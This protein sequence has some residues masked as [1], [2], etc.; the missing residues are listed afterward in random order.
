MNIFISFLLFKF[1]DAFA[2]RRYNIFS[3]F[4]DVAGGLR[5]SIDAA[6]TPCDASSKTAIICRNA[7]T[8]MN[9]V[10]ASDMVWAMLLSRFSDLQ[11][12]RSGVE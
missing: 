11:E 2:K 10:K 7:S 5:V 4:D 6:P 1:T 12:R 8:P 3:H 9:F